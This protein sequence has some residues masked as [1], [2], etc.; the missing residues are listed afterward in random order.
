MAPPAQLVPAG[1]SWAAVLCWGMSDFIGGYAARRANAFFLTTIAHASG[2]LL[3]VTLALL[4]HS[5]FP[6]R[7][8]VLWAL[9]AGLVGGGALAIFYRALATGKMGLTAP[10]AAV[11]GAAIPTV[12]GMFTEGLP[13]SVQIAGFGLAVAG[14]WLISRSEDAGRPEGLGLAALAGIG[15]ASFFLCI[16]QAGNESVSAL[17]IAA[18]S[19]SAAFVLTGLIVLLG[20]D[21][22]MTR[23]SAAFGVLAGCLDVSGSALFIRA[24]Q[25][26]RLDAAVV[27]SSLY[28]AITVLL[29]RLI[30]KEQL[31]RWKT[32]GMFAALAAAPMIALQ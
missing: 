20:R 27:I 22:R 5:E 14:I 30:L 8:S 29:A 3:M 11:L 23:P 13:G 17:W 32:V 24:S 7:T 28:P 1:F 6:S 19:R 15:F 10:V 4:N 12:F 16:K 18:V 25:T 31:T 2:G 26:G 9:A 21:F